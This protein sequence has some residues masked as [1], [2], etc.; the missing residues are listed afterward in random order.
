M[1]RV[2][3]RERTS[4]TLFGD[5]AEHHLFCGGR[6]MSLAIASEQLYCAH[7]SAY[8][9]Q[10]SQMRSSTLSL[11]VIPRVGFMSET[12]ERRK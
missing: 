3:G 4:Q 1:L 2:K 8:S 9:T 7:R 11:E 12:I 10:P 6:R 5:I